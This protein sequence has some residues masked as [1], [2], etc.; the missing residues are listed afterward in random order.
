MQ[1]S[2]AALL[3]LAVQHSELVPQFLFRSQPRAD[4]VARLLRPKRQP[5][6]AVRV[7]ATPQIPTVVV[8]AK[9]LAA[10]KYFLREQRDRARLQ[11]LDS[12]G[13]EAHN[14]LSGAVPKPLGKG[15]FVVG[16]CFLPLRDAGRAAE[17]KFPAHDEQGVPD[18]PPFGPFV[19]P[20]Q[21][22][23]QAPVLVSVTRRLRQDVRLR[24]EVLRVRAALR[25][26]LPSAHVVLARHAQARRVVVPHGLQDAVQRMLLPDVRAAAFAA[27]EAMGE[28]FVPDAPAM[29]RPR[30]S[31]AA[32]LSPRDPE[33]GPGDGIIAYRD[34]R[35]LNTTFKVYKFDHL[36][37]I[38]KWNS[39]RIG[40]SFVKH[41]G[42]H[43]NEREIEV[44]LPASL[45]R[46]MMDW[47][48]N[49]ERDSAWENYQLSVA[50]CRIL[51][52]ELAITASEQY[53]AN[54]YG[55]ALGFVRSWD[56]QQN[57]SRVVQGAHVDLRSYT[58]PKLKRAYRTRFGK[59]VMASVAV[60]AVIVAGFVTTRG[61]KQL[62]ARA[63]FA[64]TTWSLRATVWILGVQ[65]KSMGNIRAAS[66]I[67][68]HF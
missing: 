59:I 25:A 31:D 45:V 29:P 64:G 24:R 62:I 26:V 44:R 22:V 11:A 51:V 43:F 65:W 23:P 2:S 54:L 50:R 37:F 7:A 18:A 55:P 53:Y 16:N 3:S 66:A 48:T 34:R 32:I 46:E 27:H 6:N 8:S 28:D 68:P 56:R 14:L 4:I 33:E 47:W 67:L 13:Q 10:R 19:Q 17:E 52:S 39:S 9:Q 63:V 30:H 49:R 20:A 12:K 60:A 58:L 1:A 40:K 57:V 5:M 21:P 41:F 35:L 42:L 38:G 36:D 61:T 15:Q